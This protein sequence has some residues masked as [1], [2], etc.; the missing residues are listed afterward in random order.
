MLPTRRT[1]ALRREALTPL[2]AG[3]LGGLAGG[4]PRTLLA[5]CDP[6]LNTCFSCMQYISC[7]PAA[8]TFT[9]TTT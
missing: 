8:C 4:Q 5:E 7:N 2:T 6:S 3:D 1:L 9:L